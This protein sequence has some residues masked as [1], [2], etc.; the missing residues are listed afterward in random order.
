[1]FG[2][3]VD[4]NIIGDPVGGPELHRFKLRDPKSIFL[5]ASLI[6]TCS[7]CFR[8]ADA[9]EVGGMPAEYRMG[10]DWLF[11]LRLSERGDFVFV[12]EDLALVHRHPDNLTR[13]G[14]AADSRS[15]NWQATTPS[16]MALWE[17]QWTSPS[18]S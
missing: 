12:Q 7:A 18:A 6:A 15:R 9:I 16:W 14:S 10:E 1:M 8:R 2:T 3:K 17:F 5:K 4:I 13:P 11:W